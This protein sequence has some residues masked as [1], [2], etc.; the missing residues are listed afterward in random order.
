[1][2]YHK[3]LRRQIG[4]YLPAHLLEDQEMQKFLSVIHDAYTAADKDKELSERAFAIS[5]EEYREVNHKLGQ[6]IEVRKQSVEKLKETIEKITGAEKAG[7]SDDL[8]M[9]ARY[10]SQQVTRRKNAEVVF[11]S[12]I[13]HLNNAVLLE[14]EQGIIVFANQ[15]FCDLFHTSVS[16]EQLPG[17]ESY[18]LINSS[19]E[20]FTD[21][22]SFENKII[23]LLEKKESSN[24]E[25]I[26]CVDGRIF[27]RDYIPI[28]LEGKYKGSLWNYTDITEKKRKEETYKRIALVASANHSGVLFTDNFA[29][30]NWC[31]EGFTQMTGFTPEETIGKTPIEL[32]RGPLTDKHTLDKVVNS[33]YMGIPFH[34]DIIYYR[35]DGSW[36]WGRSHTQPVKDSKGNVVEFFGIIE[37]ITE[38]KES[39]NRFRLALDKIGDNV[40]EHNYFTGETKF[41]DDRHQLLGYD[42]SEFNSNKDLWWSSI[43]PD[44]ILQLQ[45][46]H[47]AYIRDGQTHHN[48]EYRM[49]HKSGDVRWVLDKGVVIEWTAENKPA[50]IIGTHT[51]ITSIKETEK[52]L[53]E[54]QEQFRSLEQNIPGVLYNYEYY[55]DGRE[56]FIY[57]SPDSEK[58]IGISEDELQNFYSI[59]HPDDRDAEKQAS[60]DARNNSGHYHFE[61]RF[62]PSGKPVQWLN[63]SSSFSHKTADGSTVF[64]GIILNTTRE[65]ETEI[66]MLNQEKRFR[67]II[68]NM[69]LG[70]LEVDNQEIIQYA[71]QSFCEMSGYS[72]AELMGQHA[73]MLFIRDEDSQMMEMKND[74]RKKGVS[75]AYEIQVKNKQGESKWWLISGAPRYGEHGELIGSVGIHLDIT[76]QKKLEYELVDARELAESSAN[77]KQSFLANMSHEIRTP[78]NAIIGMAGQ[79][80]KTPL[81]ENQHFYLK[82]INSA[83]ENLLVIINDILDLSKLEAGKLTIEEIGFKPM[84]LVHQVM[85]VMM[86]KAEEKGLLLGNSVFDHDILEVLIGDPYRINQVLL[87]LVSNA[88]KF[89]QKGSVDISCRLQSEDDEKQ[90]LEFSVKDT[91]MGMDEEFMK[92]LFQKFTQE[93][94]SVTRRF[95]GTGLGMSICKELVE[96]MGGTIS[97]E[98]KKGTGTTASFRVPLKKGSI[99]DIP[100]KETVQIRSNML[101]GKRILVTDDNEMNRLVATTILRN[102]GVELDEATNGIEAIKKIKQQAYDLVL[103][104]VQMPLMDGLEATKLIRE[105]ISRSLPVIALTAL[106]LKGDETKFIEAGMNDYLSKPFEESRLIQVIAK[107]L[108]TEKPFVPATQKDAEISAHPLFT[109]KRLRELTGTDEV[110]MDKLIEAFIRE[111]PIAVKEIKQALENQ[112][113]DKL[114][115][116]AHKLKPSIDLVG[117]TCLEQ[118]IR[119][120]EAMAKKGCNNSSLEKRIEKLES[121]LL[122]VINIL[123]TG[124]YKIQPAIS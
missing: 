113:L 44:D 85:Q 78:M 38:E 91:G 112:D 74:S 41:S 117:I 82:I 36:F 94:E 103:M 1:M 101:A 77:A 121:I 4:K 11:T 18:K 6:E 66:A 60:V 53:R 102:Y 32:C 27:E 79:L 23:Q 72:S 108:G 39:E 59:L 19:K 46:N 25:I 26:E 10:L 70:L 96:F 86:H 22:Q 47:E 69:N 98:S 109:L 8:L 43:Y 31:N 54:N 67:N 93:D 14:D 73:G 123:A 56:K 21:A 33:F 75:D 88:V 5:E 50:R 84:G 83:A 118:D 100:S 2:N 122:E 97:V 62:Q 120:I 15:H 106:A 76:E 71:N 111:S 28:F 45:K 114:A 107:W 40:W 7:Q 48:L 119:D 3:L 55:P 30:I 34:V 16:P 63:I 37:D 9:I 17:T 95:G 51:D 42:Q 64:T 92:N 104:D 116:T 12:L 24:N 49:I 105:N 57:V 99:A 58:K 89:T 110:F 13:A 20:S 68:A 81:D 90:W 124:N 80:R 115:K 61:G 35:K 87:N 65:K 52:A 29:K